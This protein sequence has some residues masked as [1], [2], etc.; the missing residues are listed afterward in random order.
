MRGRI[1]KL[2]QSATVDLRQTREIDH[3]EVLFACDKRRRLARYT[4]PRYSRYHVDVSIDGTSWK[5][6]FDERANMK[7]NV[8]WARERWFEP[9]Q[10]R[11][12]RLTVT[13]DAMKQG[14]MVV[15]M[16]V[17]GTERETME[18]PRLSFLP[19]WDVQYPEHV[20]RVSVADSLYLIK[21][22]PAKKPVLGWMPAGRQWADLNGSVKLLTS[23]DR[24]GR[25][26]KQSLYAEAP[27]EL[28]Y[29][30]PGGY[31]TFAAAAGLGAE[32]TD[33][34]VIFKVLVDGVE[35]FKSP[36]YRIGQP[37]LPVV[38]DIKGARELKLVVEDPA[39]NISAYAWWGEARLLRGK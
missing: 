14:A 4:T 19:P 13:Y 30:L 28:T 37:I 20:R 6:V 33:D 38:V 32:R 18:Q 16:K 2:P 26:Y 9:R 24:D 29:T 12:V 5:T 22:S 36:L 17:M 39:G 10:A 27:S 23:I 3:V 11:Y 8:G 15:E 21:A 7:P 31:T 34:A 25:A 1:Y 35:T